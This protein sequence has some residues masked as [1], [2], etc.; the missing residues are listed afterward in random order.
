[1]PDHARKASPEGAVAPLMPVRQRRATLAATPLQAVMQASPRVT[2]LLAMQQGMA[3]RAVQRMAVEDEAPLQ[4]KGLED[5]EPLQAAGL[6]DEEPLQGKANGAAPVQ[7]Q[8]GP[9]GNGGLP[10]Q[11]Q[12]GV[13]A[14]SGHSM[15]D[16]RVHRNS[17]QPAQVG[18][19]AY[20]QGRDIHLGPGQEK[21]LPHEAW[22]V[23]QQAQG[24][25]RPTMQAKGVAINDDAGLEAEADRMGAQALHQSKFTP[26]EVMKTGAPMQARAVLQRKSKSDITDAIMDQHSQTVAMF[27]GNANTP[28][29]R[30]FGLRELAAAIVHRG[31][32]GTQK[33]FA[34]LMNEMETNAWCVAAWVHK[35]GLGGAAG[36]ADPE[37]HITLMVGGTGYHVRVKTGSKLVLK[38]AKGGMLP[39][40]GAQVDNSVD[41]YADFAATDLTTKGKEKALKYRN[42]NGGSVPQAVAFVASGCPDEGRYSKGTETL[43]Y[44]ADTG[45]FA[46]YDSAGGGGW[47]KD[48]K[49]S[50]TARRLYFK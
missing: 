25:V 27:P 20:A 15:A 35:G 26:T 12:A 8:P 46:I 19:L 36:G 42:K 40:G 5:E 10:P 39:Q 1:M 31:Y 41:P 50:K 38:N 9:G 13:E 18:A 28:I 48:V 49:A 22:H 23:V 17:P 29:T 21:H 6:E 30:V 47:K 44:R 32:S 4:G 7:A 37:P 16:V 43:R 14:L 34:A 3:A 45:Y 24:R 33:D 11:L 2:Q